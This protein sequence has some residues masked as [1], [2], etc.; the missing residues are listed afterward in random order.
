[1]EFPTYLWSIGFLST[2]VGA[3]EAIV[4]PVSMTVL[5]TGKKI[6]NNRQTLVTPLWREENDEQLHTLC[7]G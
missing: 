4:L 2:V 6:G 7:G 1:M 3:V 5:S